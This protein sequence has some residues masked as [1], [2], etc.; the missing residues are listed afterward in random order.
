VKGEER[1]DRIRI[2]ELSGDQD[3]IPLRVINNLTAFP[4][5]GESFRAECDF[6][7]DAT[8]LSTGKSM[9]VEETGVTF[10]PEKRDRTLSLRDVPDFC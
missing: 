4:V 8:F 9:Q 6:V 3:R 10:G 1:F 5:G 7:R 2:L